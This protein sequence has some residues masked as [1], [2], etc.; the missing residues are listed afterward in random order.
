[1][2]LLGFREKQEQPTCTFYSSNS[3]LVSDQHVVILVYKHLSLSIVRAYPKS[4][5]L[6]SF[7]VVATPV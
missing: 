6:F 3:K 5:G 1:M 4:E 2:K 7:T